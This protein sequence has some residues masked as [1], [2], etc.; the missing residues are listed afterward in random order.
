MIHLDIQQGTPEWD[1]LRIGIPTASNFDKIITPAKLQPSKQA[2]TYLNQILA[3][4][5][6]G[7]KL[8]FGSDSLYAQ[9]G[10]RM[11]AE[12]RAFYEFTEDVEV[13]NGG[14][15]M[16]D[17]RKVGGSPD[18]LVDDDGGVELKVPAIHTHIGYM[19][20]PQLLVAD[21][22]FQAQ[23]YLYLTERA[24]WDIQSYCPTLPRVKVRVTR[25][26]KFV[27]ALHA[28]LEAFVQY[29]DDAKEQLAQFK[30]QP[31]AVA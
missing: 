22:N 16:R 21:Y 19:R 13:V 15:V 10:T 14:F 31:A 30:Y 23:G 3:E 11:E 26:D 2:D 29:L 28:G 1:K 17:D 25:D 18:G 8:E 20:E 5:L 9:R 4:W 27:S 7:M 12:A 6:L 24:W